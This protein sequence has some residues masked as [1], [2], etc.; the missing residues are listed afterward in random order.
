MTALHLVNHAAA[1]RDCLAVAADDDAVLLIENGVYMAAKE[2][3]P[4]RPLYA[5]DVDVGARGLADRLADHVQVV[6][7]ADF[8]GLVVAHSPIVTWR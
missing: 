7:D 3:A 6:T 4:A 2:I 8:V 1:L 5:L